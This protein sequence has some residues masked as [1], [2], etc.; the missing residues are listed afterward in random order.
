MFSLSSDFH[1]FRSRRD[2]FCNCFCQV[3]LFAKLIEV[4]DLKIRSQPDSTAV[5]FELAEQQFDD[6]TFADT[7]VTDQ[8]EPIS[9]HQFEVEIADNSSA[10]ERFCE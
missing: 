9:P 3:K 10:S 7:V 8:S 6:R 5:G 4:C 1:P 2:G